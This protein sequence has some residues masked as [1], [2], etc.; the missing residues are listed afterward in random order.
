M[1]GKLSSGCLVL[2]CCV[3]LCA[4]DTFTQCQRFGRCFQVSSFFFN[5]TLHL[6]DD[7]HIFD[8][9]CSQV[10]DS[11]ASCLDIPSLPSNGDY[12]VLT[13]NAGVKMQISDLVFHTQPPANWSC[14]IDLL[15]SIDHISSLYSIKQVKWSEN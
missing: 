8:H 15:N 5:S 2:L 10:C 4:A 13:N 1:S 3:V 12:I 9:L 7:L 11:A 14:F 6:S